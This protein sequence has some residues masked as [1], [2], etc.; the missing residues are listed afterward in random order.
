MTK[1]AIDHERC[2]GCGWCVFVCPSG[3]L[4]TEDDHIVAFSLEECS[5]CKE[6][7]EQCPEAAIQIQ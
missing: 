2:V 4:D 3:V 6:C 5:R 7:E 1:I